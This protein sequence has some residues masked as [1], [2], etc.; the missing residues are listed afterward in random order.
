MWTRRQGRRHFFRRAPPLP[1]LLPTRPLPPPCLLFTLPFC[2]Q[3]LPAAP[4]LQTGGK[5]DSGS[6]PSST[7]TFFRRVPP[8]PFLLPAPLLPPPCPHL[9]SP[10]RLR[11]RPMCSCAYRSAATTSEDA[12]PRFSFAFPLREAGRSDEGASDVTG[13]AP[14]RAGGVSDAGSHPSST[15]TPEEARPSPRPTTGRSSEDGSDPDDRA[16]DSGASAS[17]GGDDDSDPGGPGSN[18]SVLMATA[19]ATRAEQR[20][21]ERK[22]NRRPWEMVAQTNTSDDGATAGSSPFSF[23]GRRR[24]APGCPGLASRPSS[25]RRRR[26]TTRSRYR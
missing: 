15:R 21:V 13:S 24:H 6:H 18:S 8:L 26:T 22:A 23:G 2:A 10:P 3:L 11:R 9:I 20:R 4:P 14:P 5:G 19:W 7:K 17:L 1:F 12:L 16:A 25:W